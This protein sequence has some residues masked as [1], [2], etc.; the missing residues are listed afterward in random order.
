M[1]DGQSWS[2]SYDP[3]LY[4]G[5]A[6]YYIPGRPPYSR[7]LVPLLR[8]ELGLDGT[9]RLLDVG[10]GPGV[11]TLELAACFEEAIGLEPDHDMIVEGQRLEVERRIDNVGWVEATAEEIPQ[12]GLGTFRLVTFGQSFQWTDRDVVAR[13]VFGILEP[14]GVMAL[15]GPTVEG[16][17]VPAGPGYPLI[18][19]A[20]V[21]AIIARYLGERRRA[22]QGLRPE[23]GEPYVDTLSRAGF[24]VEEP[25]FA[26]GRRDIIQDVDGVIANYLSTSFSAPHL[27][28][29]R[30]LDFMKD[31][32]A[33]LQYQSSEGIFW[34]WPGDTEVLIAR[35]PVAADRRDRHGAGPPRL[36][37]QS[38]PVH[39]HPRAR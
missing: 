38:R 36:L 12:L 22:G 7:D 8:A 16:R 2:G 11:L 15:I 31:V 5:S 27:F 18:P 9:G 6:R 39:S 35:K 34:D 29:E 3:T 33:E 10:A 37:L 13:A 14:A 30:L 25:R 26:E 4:K 23:R 1:T 17:P 20:A 28:G 21:R 19:H 32:R 24:D